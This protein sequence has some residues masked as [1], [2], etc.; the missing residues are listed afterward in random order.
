[1][2]FPLSFQTKFF[3]GLIEEASL[4]LIDLKDKSVN[5]YFDQAKYIKD[6]IFSFDATYCQDNFNSQFFLLHV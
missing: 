5:T 3:R 1:M 2:N 6:L 4:A